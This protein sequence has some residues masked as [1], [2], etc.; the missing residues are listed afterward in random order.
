[1][2]AHFAAA[3]TP[4]YRG[5]YDFEIRHDFISF[6]IFIFPIDFATKSTVRIHRHDR[7]ANQFSLKNSPLP[8]DPALDEQRI[9]TST[10]F[11]LMLSSVEAFIDFF[12]EN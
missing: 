12:S 10:G 3:F 5:A 11:P 2:T 4:R 1:L 6:G 8:S 9:Q 7:P